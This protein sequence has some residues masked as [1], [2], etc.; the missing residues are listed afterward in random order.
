L[1]LSLV[2][3]LP[4]LQTRAAPPTH[5]PPEQVSLVVQAFPSSHDDVLF[6]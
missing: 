5:V 2:H 4:S 1:Q 6:V 3:T